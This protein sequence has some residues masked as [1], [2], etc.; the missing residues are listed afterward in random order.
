MSTFQ[1]LLISELKK[2]RNASCLLENYEMD[3]K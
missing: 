2:M 1:V 3:E